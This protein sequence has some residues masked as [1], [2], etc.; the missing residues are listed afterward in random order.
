MSDE[1]GRMDHRYQFQTRKITLECLKSIFC[2]TI[3]LSHEVQVIDSCFSDGA[4]DTF[5]SEF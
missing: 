3:D 2:E 4:F 5:K 1:S